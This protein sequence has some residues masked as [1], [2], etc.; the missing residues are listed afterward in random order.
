MSSPSSCWTDSLLSRRH[1]NMPRGNRGL[2]FVVVRLVLVDGTTIEGVRSEVE[3]TDQHVAV[4][5]HAPPLRILPDLVPRL[6]I[7]HEEVIADPVV[8]DVVFERVR[9]D[10]PTGG[11]GD[12]IRWQIFMPKNQKKEQRVVILVGFDSDDKTWSDLCDYVQAHELLTFFGDA[13]SYTDTEDVCRIASI[14]CHDA[15]RTQHAIYELARMGHQ[16]FCPNETCRDIIPDRID[17]F[18]HRWLDKSKK[19]SPERDATRLD[20]SWFPQEDELVYVWCDIAGHALRKLQMD[21]ATRREVFER[22]ARLEK[23]LHYHVMDVFCERLEAEL[24]SLASRLQCLSEAAAANGDDLRD[25]QA[26]IAHVRTDGVALRSTAMERMA[27]GDAEAALSF[28]R[29]ATRR[30][31]DLLALEAE[32]STIDETV[33]RICADIEGARAEIK[34]IEWLLTFRFHRTSGFRWKRLDPKFAPSTDEDILVHPR[35]GELLMT[36]PRPSDE[37][38]TPIWDITLTSEEIATLSDL[39]VLHSKS[40]LLHEGEYFQPETLFLVTPAINSAQNE[41]L[42][43][44]CYTSRFTRPGH[45][46]QLRCANMFFRYFFNIGYL[47]KI[48]GNYARKNMHRGHGRKLRQFRTDP[49]LSTR[50]KRELFFREACDGNNDVLNRLKADGTSFSGGKRP[51]GRYRHEAADSNPKR[52]RRDGQARMDSLVRQSWPSRTEGGEASTSTSPGPK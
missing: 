34:E 27:A 7:A 21:G 39:P 3:S 6:R 50:E 4:W 9:P 23:P 24:S 17:D 52:K 38:A 42:N 11:L 15:S 12:H 1:I 8:P 20:M 46:M 30:Q 45:A 13:P 14:E 47:A 28:A 48:G 49:D 40:I 19:S 32:P 31:C 51:G 18:V 26:S 5:P 36:Q 16:A 10:P 22:I 25:C 44:M 29:S 33:K 43:A 37:E 2:P 35:L 41:Q